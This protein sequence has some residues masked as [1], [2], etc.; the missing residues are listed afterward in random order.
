[1]HPDY[2]V[3]ISVSLFKL[4]DRLP[5]FWPPILIGPPLPIPT[6]FLAAHMA[7]QNKAYVAQPPLQLGVIKSAQ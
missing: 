6:G 1:M 7:A 2:D 4:R 5:F 3:D